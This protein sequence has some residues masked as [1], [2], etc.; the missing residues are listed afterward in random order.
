MS[1]IMHGDVTGAGE[2]C[3]DQLRFEPGPQEYCSC[4]LPPN[5]RTTC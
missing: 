4:T 2:K 1:K 3:W 5:Y